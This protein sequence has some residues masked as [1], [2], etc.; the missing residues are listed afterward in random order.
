MCQVLGD[1]RLVDEPAVWSQHARDLSQRCARTRAS[2]SGSWAA[3]ARSN[4]LACLRS[5][6]RDGSIG[7]DF[8]GTASSFHDLPV[9]R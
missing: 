4:C 2:A 1:R 5:D 7:S 8:V 3:L 9:T 6:A